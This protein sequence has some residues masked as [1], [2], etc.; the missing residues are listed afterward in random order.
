MLD[1]AQAHEISRTSSHP[2]LVGAVEE[3]DGAALKVLKML[4]AARGMPDLSDLVTRAIARDRGGSSSL[5]VFE[6][7]LRDL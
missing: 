1:V 4:G 7:D 2:E 5:R 3:L 6:L